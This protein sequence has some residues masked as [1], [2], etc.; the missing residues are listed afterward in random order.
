M[1]SVFTT[2]AL[3]LLT[4]LPSSSAVRPPSEV[5]TR[6]KGQIVVWEEEE[7]AINVDGTSTPIRS[8]W[9]DEN[10][11]P[12]E[13]PS[14]TKAPSGPSASGLTG[15]SWS[16][17]WKIDVKK[18]KDGWQD[19]T[20]EGGKIRIRRRKWL[21]EYTENTSRETPSL[22]ETGKAKGG[23]GDAVADVDVDVDGATIASP[24]ILSS[25]MKRVASDYNFRGF[26]FSIYKSI[27]YRR[28]GGVSLRMP[29]T[30]NFIS[31]FQRPWLPS[32]NSS[33]GLYHP[34]P[35]IAFFVSASLPIDVVRVVVIR[36]LMLIQNMFLE[37][38]RKHKIKEGPIR[39]STNVV[40]RVG[41]SVSWRYCGGEGE[42]CGKVIFKVAPWFLWLP[43]ITWILRW[44]DKFVMGILSTGK[45]GGGGGGGRRRQYDDRRIR[46][47]KQIATDLSAEGSW[48]GLKFSVLSR[49]I[50][51]KFAPFTEQLL[52]T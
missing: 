3:A 8:R 50:D 27:L 34:G 46:I 51:G 15:G 41:V 16:G 19:V 49:R 1:R 30:Q 2:I 12:C 21:R 39:S 26:G 29:I 36:N 40:Q 33:I 31:Y 4:T 10:F 9:V 25:A 52:P 47:K 32:I 11:S 42:N 24:T 5:R 14:Q 28:A 43:A 7:F 38:R 48:A 45:G 20:K 22:S 18:T 44:V 13:P 37:A 35:T 23:G 17:S 6:R